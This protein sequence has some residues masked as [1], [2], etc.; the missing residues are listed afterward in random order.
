VLAITQKGIQLSCLSPSSAA[1]HLDQSSKAAGRNVRSGRAPSVQQQDPQ[2]FHCTVLLFPVL[3]LLAQRIHHLRAQ[4]HGD[5]LHIA[6]KAR[7]CS[8]RSS[9]GGAE[10]MSCVRSR[11]VSAMDTS[12][13]THT[14]VCLH[15]RMRAHMRAFVRVC[16]HSLACV[17]VCV[18]MRV[19]VRV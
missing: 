11:A 9:G 15:V 8:S 16:M 10:C 4:L 2:G 14:H 6:H 7:L 3:A 17:H 19:C 12:M 5:P 13:F 1:N 18:C